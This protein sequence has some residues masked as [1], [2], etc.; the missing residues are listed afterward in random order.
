[1]FLELIDEGNPLVAAFFICLGGMV[2]QQLATKRA[3]MEFPSSLFG[4]N[5][6]LNWAGVIHLSL[7][8]GECNGCLSEVGSVGL[9]L[10]GGVYSISKRILPFVSVSSSLSIFRRC[11][12]LFI[13]MFVVAVGCRFIRRLM[14]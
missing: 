9:C 10:L 7:R 8:N 12:C 6:L 11:H 1:M 4:K 14:I 2:P 13:A 3:I 5:A